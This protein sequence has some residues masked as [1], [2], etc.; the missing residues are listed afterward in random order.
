MRR[1]SA[2]ARLSSRCALGVV[3]TVSAI[4]RAAVR[5]G[6]RWASIRLARVSPSGRSL[7]HRRD[8]GFASMAVSAMA[9]AILIITSIR[10]RLG[11]ARV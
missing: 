5:V 11:R 6:I 9:L 4:H 2:L 3:A 8:S 1:P 10:G 7:A